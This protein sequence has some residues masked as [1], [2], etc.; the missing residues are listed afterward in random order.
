NGRLHFAERRDA[1]PT[2]LRRGSRHRLRRHDGRPRQRFREV[3][4]I[5]TRVL[6]RG[7]TGREQGEY[8]R[9]QDERAHG[10]YHRFMACRCIDSGGSSASSMRMPFGSVMLLRIAFVSLVR[11]SPTFTPR[12]LNISVAAFMF[13]TWMP[14]WLMAA[15]RPGPGWISKKV[16]LLICT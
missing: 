6:R 13:S 3:G 8:R 1:R 11:I 16:F 12:A 2:P 4:N 5:G 9:A 15:G 10:D 14:T 7:E